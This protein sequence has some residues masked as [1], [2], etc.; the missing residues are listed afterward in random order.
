LIGNRLF[1]DFQKG[2]DGPQTAT[3][4]IHETFNNYGVV[5][6]NNVYQA[7]AVIWIQGVN[8]DM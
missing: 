6:L 4:L 3:Q 8:S 1:I 5:W 2:I 7:E